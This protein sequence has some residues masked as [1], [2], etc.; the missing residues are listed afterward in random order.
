MASG[1]LQDPS[2]KTRSP[3]KNMKINHKDVGRKQDVTFLSREVG[4]DVHYRGLSQL[5][6]FGQ[7]SPEHSAG[8]MHVDFQKSSAF[9]FESTQELCDAWL[10][11]NATELNASGLLCAWPNWDY[12]LKNFSDWFPVG[13]E[14]SFDL[15]SVF[16]AAS[17]CDSVDTYGFQE[18]D[19]D[20]FK[21]LGKLDHVP[22]CPTPHH[23]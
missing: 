4:L 3:N 14:P 2:R 5:R 16:L 12:V 23:R 13:W 10:C 7:W 17:M 1:L 22:L 9:L 21:S 18:F 19:R 11:G 15:R 20:F 6:S 8:R